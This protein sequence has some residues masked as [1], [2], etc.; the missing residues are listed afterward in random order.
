MIDDQDTN[1][2]ILTHLQELLADGEAYG[3]PVVLVYHAAW[4]QHLQQGLAMWRDHNTKLKLRHALVWHRVTPNPKASAT[5]AQPCKQPANV[6]NQR[7]QGPFSEVAQPETKA[8]AA[9]NKGQ[10]VDGTAHPDALHV[11]RY[12][13]HMRAWTLDS[14]TTK[15]FSARGKDTKEMGHG[16]V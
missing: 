13:L 12:C 5:S 14:A 10:C 15:S 1:G 4:L 8:C 6:R 11:C 16:G 2:R 9:F 7:R 3:W